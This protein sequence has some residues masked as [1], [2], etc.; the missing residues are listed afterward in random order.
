[1]K[2]T[3]LQ[4]EQDFFDKVKNALPITGQYYRDGIRP[5]ENVATSEDCLVIYKTGLDGDI[6][7]GFITIN[8]YV[9]D[10]SFDGRKLKDIGRCGVIESALSTFAETLRIPDYMIER[11]GTI[12]TFKVIETDEHFVH[13]EL[14]YNYLSI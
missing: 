9:P 7:V 8:V 14:K 3:G 11:E 2:K 6:Q 10:L 4:F 13:L 12:K 1:M 5:L